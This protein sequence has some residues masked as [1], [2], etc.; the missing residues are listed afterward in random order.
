MASLSHAQAETPPNKADVHYDEWAEDVDEDPKPAISSVQPL[1]QDPDN[2][3]AEA[4]ARYPND[5]SIDARDE[6]K[7]RRKLDRLIIPLLGGCY[8]FYYV[9]KT[10]LYVLL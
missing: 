8:F 9:D 3:Y 1:D 7:I 6:R 2:I 4:L 10:T 5:E